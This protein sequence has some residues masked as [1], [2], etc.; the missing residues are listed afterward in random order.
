VSIHR[1]T[2]PLAV[3]YRAYRNTGHDFGGRSS[4]SGSLSVWVHHLKSFEYLPKY[5]L[6]Q[7]TGM[8]VRVGAG[9]EAWEMFNH[10]GANNITVPAPCCTVGMAGGWIGSGGHSTIVSTLGLGA[11]QVLSAQVVTA[12]GRLVTADPNTNKDL[13]WAIRGGGAGSQ[14]L[15][16]LPSCP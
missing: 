7:Y 9:V 4:G 16:R 10:M 5:T 2:R 1:R 12:E 11:D 15:A 13:F 14:P 6:G 3:T 8:A